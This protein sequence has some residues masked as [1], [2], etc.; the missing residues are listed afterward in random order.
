MR[1]DRR[2]ARTA[3]LISPSPGLVRTTKAYRAT[4]L[5]HDLSQPAGPDLTSLLLLVS[6]VNKEQI[7]LSSGSAQL[8][9]SASLE[10]GPEPATVFWHNHYSRQ[11]WPYHPDTLL[12]KIM[13][14]GVLTVSSGCQRVIF[15]RASVHRTVENK[16]TSHMYLNSNSFAAL[17]LYFKAE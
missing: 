1:P 14:S 4:L 11:D 10:N 6:T 5:S 2:S 15:S 3:A 17:I 12:L 8:G 13:P 9:L 16:L 7:V